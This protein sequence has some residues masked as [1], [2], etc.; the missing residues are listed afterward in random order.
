MTKLNFKYN[1]QKD[2]WSH[3]FVLKSQSTLENYGKKSDEYEFIPY[4]LAIKIK[5]HLLK[6]E[7][8]C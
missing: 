3:V 6:K 2:I 4:G 7:K 5:K 1:K 8:T